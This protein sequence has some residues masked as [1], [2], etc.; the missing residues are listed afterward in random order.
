M[1][2]LEHAKTELDRLGFTLDSDEESNRWVRENVLELIQTFSDQGHSGMSAPYVLDLFSRL[3]DWKP[4][5]PLT[6]EDDEWYDRGFDEEVMQN[7]RYS[8]VFKNK[9]TGRAYDVRGIV[10]WEWRVDEETGKRYKSHFISKESS[11]DIEFPYV[12]PN[13]PEYREK[14]S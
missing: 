3:A 11:I 9:K 10:F 2:F 1:N 5:S 13:E 7:K 6:G 14:M 4:L 12:V 8:S